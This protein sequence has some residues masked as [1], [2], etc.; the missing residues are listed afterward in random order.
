MSKFPL[1]PSLRRTWGGFER[2]FPQRAQYLQRKAAASAR[3]AAAA[4]YD[5]SQQKA[6]RLHAKVSTWGKD[7]IE[8]VRVWHLRGELKAKASNHF[9]K[10]AEPAK[11][12]RGS[13]VFTQNPKKGFA[14]SRANP[15][16]SSPAPTRSP[17]T[18]TKGRQR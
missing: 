17:P 11:P 8:K 4:G 3:K 13:T 16:S 1:W 7:V 5:L 14:A 12:Q 18:A 10:A 6:P 15:R 9:A 2:L